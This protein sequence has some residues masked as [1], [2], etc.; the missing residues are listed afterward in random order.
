[1]PGCRGREGTVTWVPVVITVRYR[2]LESARPTANFKLNSDA[3][4]DGAAAAAAARRTRRP[5]LFSQ[6]HS[7]TH[8]TITQ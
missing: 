5:F 4:S 1:M 2:N 7:S 8:S 6:S 3:D